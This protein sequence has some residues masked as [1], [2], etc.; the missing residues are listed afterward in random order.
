M[1]KAWLTHLISFLV[2]IKSGVL[3]IGGGAVIIPFLT[4]CHVPIRKI[5]AIASLC[6][7]TIAVVGSVTFMITGWNEPNLPLGSTG[8]VYWPAVFAV[9]LPSMMCA[10]LGAKLAYRV[11][12][13]LIRRAFIVFLL[14]TAIHLLW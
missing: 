13:L 11:P 7:M 2:G 4:R 12:I 9:A 6:S 1:P 10:P 5:A 14:I 8:Y 3:G